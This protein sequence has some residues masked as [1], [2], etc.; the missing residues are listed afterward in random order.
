MLSWDEGGRIT[1]CNVEPN[2]TGKGEILHS[3]FHGEFCFHQQ[4]SIILWETPSFK[5]LFYWFERERERLERERER[6]RERER[7]QLVHLL[8]HLFF[9]SCMRP[10]QGSNPQPWSIRMTLYKTEVH[11]QGG[12]HVLEGDFL[13]SWCVGKRLSTMGIRETEE[14]CRLKNVPT[15]GKFCILKICY[16]IEWWLTVTKI[17]SFWIWVTVGLDVINSWTFVIFLT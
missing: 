16:V 5:F 13:A 11:S 15:R 10:D 14:I 1:G 17:I 9:D 4:I 6:L 2:I 7:D 8:M 3:C 12:K